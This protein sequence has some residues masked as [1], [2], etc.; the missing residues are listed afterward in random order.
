MSLGNF[1]KKIWAAI[2]KV[3][4]QIGKEARKVISVSHDVVENIKK[5]VDSPTADLITALIPGT[6]D[7]AIKDRLRIILPQV[8]ALLAGLRDTQISDVD[9]QV[10]KA[11]VTDV[12]SMHPDAKKIFY[13]G[14]A[15]LLTEKLSDQTDRPINW[16]ESVAL[17]EYHRKYEAA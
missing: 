11:V 16:S 3:F 1:L 5:F 6:A 7:D 2:E 17:Q 8:L 13:H 12:N 14:I 15:A 10:L 9:E 4:G